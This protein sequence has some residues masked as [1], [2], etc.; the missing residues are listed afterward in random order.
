MERNLFYYAKT[1]VKRIFR[2]MDAKEKGLTHE[3]AKKRLKV[4]GLNSVAEEKKSGVIIEFLSHF[5]NPLILILIVA[6]GLSFIFRE[7]V[8]GI[9]IF[10]LVLVG[11]VLDFI[12]EHSAGK[13]AEK[14]KEMLK[15]TCAAERDGRVA[16]IDFKFVVPGD[17]LHFSAGDI[18]P[19]DCRII[20]SQDLFT[21]QSTLTGES[22]PAAKHAALMG[23]KAESLSD[24]ENIVFAGT[25]VI[26]GTAKAIVV[27]TGKNTEFGKIAES[28]VKVEEE[29]DFDKGIKQ[30]GYLIMK[31]TLFIVIFVFFF[32]AFFKHEWLQSFLFAISIAVG[33]TPELLPMIMSIN[34]SKGSMQMSKHGVIVKKLTAIPNFGSMDI[35]CTDKTGTLTEGHITLIKHIDLKGND[36]EEVFLYSYLNSHFQTGLKNPMDHAILEHQHEDVKNYKKIDEIPFDFIR[37]R[38]SIVVETGGKQILITKGSP[39]DVFK[40]CANV[41]GKSVKQV[42]ED[43]IYKEYLDLSKDGF[44]VL[45]IAIREIDKNKKVYE[46][47]DE[48]DLNLIGFAAFLDPP[49]KSAEEALKHL[50]KAGIEV[51]IITGDNELVTEKICSEIDLPIKGILLGKDI[52]K[53]SDA[54]LQIRVNK[55]TIFARCA[56]EEKNRIIRVLRLNGHTVGYIG[57]GINDAPSLKTADVGI[58]VSNATDIAKESA[59]II[60]TRPSLDDL[61]NGV[62]EGRKTFGNTIKYIMMGVSSNFGNMFSVIGAVMFVPFLPMLPVQILLNNFIY[63]FSQ[64]TIPSDNVD[65]EFIKKPKKWN[66]KFI[67]K[68]MLIF[69]PISSL[70]DFATFFL[71]Y[72]IF[73]SS[74]GAFQTGW[75]IE[76]LA[77]QTLVIHVIRSKKLSFIKSRA[78]LALTLTTISAVALGWILPYTPIGTLFGLVPLP[79]KILI[80]IAALVV[81]YLVVVEFGKWLFYKKYDF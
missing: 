80:S 42:N 50:E 15:S 67:K 51:K 37:K 9:I 73:E 45:A 10:G 22:Y 53:M 32:N 60:L 28:S 36:N 25:S 43:A 27:L 56:P 46:P 30:F 31:A 57:D 72:K 75:F 77:T 14:L 58:S 6:A 24:L 81:I 21:D 11:V 16:E 59:D 1:D 47:E 66:I 48:K 68:F 29:S 26:S 61:I 69:G 13:A 35:L 44:R 34:M 71:L 79:P 55:T 8:N 54:E 7:V 78:S 38:M 39:E 5:K 49:K 2:D 70:F 41:S 4:F 40:A 3:E 76:S 64:I 23:G 20:E 17:I 33:L 74:A 12:Q 63:D 52:E 65:A 62:I 19:A 18:I